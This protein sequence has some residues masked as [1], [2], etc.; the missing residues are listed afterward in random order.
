MFHDAGQSEKELTNLFL[1]FKY[2]T[3]ICAVLAANQLFLL[4]IRPFSFVQSY[5]VVI[6]FFWIVRV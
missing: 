3:E 1:E 5:A 4:V 6:L 2:K